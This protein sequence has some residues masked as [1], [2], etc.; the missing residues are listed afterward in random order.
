MCKKL[1]FLS[2]LIL[3]IGAVDIAS[4]VCEPYLLSDLDEDCYVNFKDLARL[5]EYWLETC[6]IPS[7]CEWVDIYTPGGDGIVDINDLDKL[8]DQWLQCTDSTNPDC[9]PLPPYIAEADLYEPPNAI[10]SPANPT[11]G[12][13]L[14]TGE[15]RETVVD[16]RIPGRG[17]DFVWS[18][19]YRSRTGSNTSAGNNWDYSYNIYI[20]PRPGFYRAQRQRPTRPL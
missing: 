13:N 5:A 20:E 4:G 7:D 17:L 19:T 8:A 12:V 9:E 3:A 2:C 10:E 15:Y 1:V 14:A 11:Y 16:L 6:D 18:R